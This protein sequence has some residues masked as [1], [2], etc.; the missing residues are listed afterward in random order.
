M[1]T[2][3]LDVPSD[4]MQPFFNMLNKLGIDK[5]SINAFALQGDK[6][7]SNTNSTYSNGPQRMPGSIIGW[8]FFKN[9][10]EYE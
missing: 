3:I 6:K 9:E 1:A 5:N 4:K 2:V 10:L 7:R 8:E